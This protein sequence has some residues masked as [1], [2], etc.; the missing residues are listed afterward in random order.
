[1]KI[2]GEFKFNPYEEKGLNEQVRLVI[3]DNQKNEFCLMEVLEPK[4]IF[5]LKHIDL[6]NHFDY[7]FKYQIMNFETNRWTDLGDGYRYLTPE[8]LDDSGLKYA[9][10]PS[11]N[12]SNHLV[13]CFQAIQTVP[14][15][16]YIR[17]LRDIDVNRLY[18]KDCYGT[19]KNTHASF[20]LDEKNPIKVDSLVQELIYSY[21]NYLSI[22]KE[23]TIF[24]GSSKGG[25]AALYHGYKFNGGHIISGGPR[26]LLGNFQKVSEVKIY[27]KIFVSI[28]GDAEANTKSYANGLLFNILKKSKFRYPNCYIHVGKGEPHYKEHVVHF[29]QWVQD[30]KIPNFTLDTMNYDTHEELG[31]YFPDYLTRKIKKITGF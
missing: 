9:F 20:Y 13:I 23:N 5:S 19:D 8:I 6:E 2:T 1:M 26:I 12:P 28:F 21:I 11:K 15:Y 3:H 17:T 7:K 25:Y 18:I 10:Y 31:K 29:N 30:L 27:P 22:P 4:T 24:I 14:G 16:N